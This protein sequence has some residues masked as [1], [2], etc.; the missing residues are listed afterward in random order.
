MVLCR[1]RELVQAWNRELEVMKHLQLCI[2]FEVGKVQPFRVMIPGRLL[3]RDGEMTLIERRKKKK[4]D[5]LHT[6][7]AVMNESL[8]MS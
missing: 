2:G 3:I 4:V 1:D 8:V 6:P 5:L 7:L